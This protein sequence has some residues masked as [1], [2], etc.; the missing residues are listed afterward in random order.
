MRQSLLERLRC[1]LSQLDATNSF[2]RARLRDTG[3]T[4]DIA[5]LDDFFQRVPFTLKAELAADQADNPPFGT[6]LTYPPTAYTR[7]SQTSSTTGRPLV[8][9]DTPESWGWMLRNWQ[10][11]LVSAGVSRGDR[12]YFAFS[13]GPFVGFWTGFESAAQLGCLCIPGGGQTSASR[14][15]TLIESKA[16]VLCCTPTY[17]LRL[18]EVAVDEHIDLREASVR[19]VLVAGEPGGSI[20]GIRERISAAWTGAE[21]YDHY[22]LTE[23]GAAAYQE[24]DEPTIL[25]ALDQE[26]LFEVIDPA[27]RTQVQYGQVGEL[28][29]TTLGRAG[30]PVLRY[31]TGDLVRPISIGS[32]KDGP[33]LGF[34]GGVIGRADEVIVVRGVNVFP[35]AVAD[36]MHRCSGVAEYQAHLSRAGALTQLELRIELAPG[37]DPKA[38]TH[39]VERRLRDALA[40]RVPVTTVPQG[41]LPRFDM[42]AQRWP[43]QTGTT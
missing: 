27:Q 7:F 32:T 41:S 30:S 22:G 11:V 36:V 8:W 13:F 2:Y 34:D 3:V 40:L 42:K 19:K 1:L 9:L 18:G 6:N 24:R 5:S 23:A 37:A 28:V 26:I 25:R 35:S 17:A 39:Q 15:R 33:R 31:R 12:V 29:L 4:A 14:L 38:V 43:R 16:T 21:I 10:Q 20:T